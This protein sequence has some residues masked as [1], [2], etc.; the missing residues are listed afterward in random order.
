MEGKPFPRMS[1]HEVIDR[2]LDKGTA[3]AV[4]PGGALLFTGESIVQAD[5]IR[6]DRM[7]EIGFMYVIVMGGRPGTSEHWHQ[8]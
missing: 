4:I 7:I 6:L 2:T 3:V 5:K 1:L 8:N